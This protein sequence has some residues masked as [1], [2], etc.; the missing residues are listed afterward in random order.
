MEYSVK[1]KSTFFINTHNLLAT[2]HIDL[3]DICAYI[4][5]K[6]FSMISKKQTL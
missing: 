1:E 3:I 4:T 6:Q 5:Y 2:L